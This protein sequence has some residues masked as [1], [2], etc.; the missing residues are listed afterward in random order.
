[1][2]RARTTG[3]FDAFLDL[4][5]DLQ[6]E[7]KQI[8]DQRAGLEHEEDGGTSA[9]LGEAQ[10][11]IGMLEKAPPAQR[12]DLRRRLRVR[13]AQMVSVIWVVIVRRGAKAVC[14]VQLYFRGSDRRRDYFILH[15][16][17]SRYTDGSWFAKSL[18]DVAGPK[19]LNLSK[20]EHARALAREL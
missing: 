12:E 18:A 17:G 2:Q 5:Q 19:K 15:T 14:A 7:R 11:I 6:D 13:I 16:P 8:I 3:D 10:S 9:D 20:R 1:R 4:I